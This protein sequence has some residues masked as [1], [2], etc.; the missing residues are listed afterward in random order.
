MEYC[1]REAE[2]KYHLEEEK[3]I[4]WNIKKQPGTV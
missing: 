2:G 1:S 4:E 3:F